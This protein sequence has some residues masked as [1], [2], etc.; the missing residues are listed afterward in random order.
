MP[1]LYSDGEICRQILLNTSDTNLTAKWLDRLGKGKRR[2]VKMLMGHS[3]IWEAMRPVARF[4]GLWDDIQLGNFAK[5][6][7]AHSDDAIVSYWK[8]INTSWSAIFEGIDALIPALDPETVRKVQYTAPKRCEQD[9]TYIK[10]ILESR[11]LF[12]RIH[13]PEDRAK[14]YRNIMTLDTILPSILTFHE[15]MRYLTIGTKIIE[16]YLLP[17]VKEM[18]PRKS[19]RQTKDLIRRLELDWTGSRGCNTSIGDGHPVLIFVLPILLF[20]LTNF[21]SLGYEPPLQDVKGHGTVAGPDEASI[22]EIRR[23][24]STYGFENASVHPKAPMNHAVHGFSVTLAPQDSS[25]SAVYTLA[26]WRGG[27]PTTRT[28]LELQKTAMFSRFKSYTEE[29]E[30]STAWVMYDM[31]SAF[32]GQSILSR[33]EEY[34]RRQRVGKRRRTT[35]AEAPTI[36]LTPDSRREIETQERDPKKRNTG[37]FSKRTSQRPVGTRHRR[38]GAHLTRNG[39]ERLSRM[40]LPFTVDTAVPETRQDSRRSIPT[41]MDVETNNT[42]PPVGLGPNQTTSG[43]QVTSVP[44]LVQELRRSMPMPID[45]SADVNPSSSVSESQ[46]VGVDSTMSVPDTSHGDRRSI[47]LLRDQVSARPRGKDSTSRNTTRHTRDSYKKKLPVVRTKSPPRETA[48]DNMDGVTHHDASNLDQVQGV[49]TQAA[50]VDKPQSASEAQNSI[51]ESATKQPKAP[52]N[53]RDSIQVRRRPAPTYVKPRETTAIRQ[54][55]KMKSPD[56]VA[57]TK[58][59]TQVRTR[60]IDTPERLMH[61]EHIVLAAKEATTASNIATNDKAHD[62]HGPSRGQSHRQATQAIE[63]EDNNWEEMQT[64]QTIDLSYASSSES[65][66]LPETGQGEGRSPL[67]EEDEYVDDIG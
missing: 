32:F 3:D 65:P 25:P 13:R 53:G 56:P 37:L 23:L 18:N 49:N 48:D 50:G 1:G 51:A 5:H 46:G 35:Q 67:L 12:K 14:L 19:S 57:T 63:H 52:G 6:L 9:R 44:D 42:L 17:K 24:A 26:R 47:P 8:H 22:A 54:P 21:P 30:C 55:T 58:I 41:I 64:A 62:A 66:D 15:N 20:A 43:E 61:T 59:R 10:T 33:V 40:I 36:L 11:D 7:A 45:S 34:L 2:H 39:Q 16:R 28:V 31:L 29:P 38:P 4:T 27:K 60:N